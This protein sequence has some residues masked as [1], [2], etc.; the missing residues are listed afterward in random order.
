M[1]C[2]AALDKSFYLCTL[3]IQIHVRYML[4]M[5]YLPCKCPA[6]PYCYYSGMLNSRVNA[7]EDEKGQCTCTPL[8][9]QNWIPS[10]ISV[11]QA[12][13]VFEIC[14]LGIPF[15]EVEQICTQMDGTRNI[16]LIIYL[17]VHL[18]PT[19][20]VVSG[21][22][23]FQWTEKILEI[24]SYISFCLHELASATTLYRSQ[25]FQAYNVCSGMLV[26]LT[27]INF[28][29]FFISTFNNVHCLNWW[30]WHYWE[31]MALSILNFLLKMSISI[32][33]VI[34]FNLVHLCSYKVR[35]SLL[36]KKA[37]L[38][39]VNFYYFLVYYIFLS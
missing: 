21:R 10:N 5:Y 13:V 23:K 9:E 11:W 8:R 34:Y 1:D 2:W 31:S 37:T 38:S 14:A 6:Q 39:L 27:V 30:D 7:S 28:S 25:F 22:F 19:T 20:F 35:R 4:S 36:H 32:N 12:G 18:M 16:Q 26:K 33:Y 3:N 24:F 17:R 15:R 29:S